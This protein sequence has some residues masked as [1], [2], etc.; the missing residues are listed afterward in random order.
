MARN[1]ILHARLLR[2]SCIKWML[3][4]MS[5]L[6]I[7]RSKG[8]LH[9]TL[10]PDPSL[11]RPASW[12]NATLS[13][14]V[15]LMKYEKVFSTLSEFS[16]TKAV[17]DENITVIDTNFSDIPVR[18]YFLKKNSEKQRPA[19]IFI[20]GGIFV[21]GSVKCCQSISLHDS[22]SEDYKVSISFF[23]E[24]PANDALNRLT[25]KKLG[26]V[27]VGIDYRL[28]PKN[29]FPASLED[30]IFAVKFFLQDKVLAKYRVDPARICIAGDSSGASLVALVTQTLQNDP[31]FKG[32]IKAQALIY[33]GLQMI[34]SYLPSHQDYEHGPILFRNMAFKL[35]SLY[36]SEDTA[37]AQAILRNEHMP[38][39]SRHLFKF[40][41]WSYFLPEKYKKN[42]VYTEPILGKLNP[43]YP[44]LVDSRLSPLLASDSQLQS[45]PL[46]YILTCEHDLVRDDG[47]IYLSRLRNVGV[48]VTHDHIED[49]IHAALSYTT[50]TVVLQLGFRIRDRYINWLV[51]NL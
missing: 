42:H 48:Q 29:I 24:V 37:L 14:N 43:S 8:R 10:I 35:V 26:A 11:L 30:C 9:W 27:V 34:D 39:G 2:G 12:D 49:G 45:V 22:Q 44:A 13:E 18:L 31:E 50:G 36:V 47:L 19:V 41:N 46:T 4:W 23:S 25:A 33:P 40:V 7:P 16:F 32:R 15:G 5:L 51:E 1:M 28:A 6:M 3:V 20:H 17:S 38:E 21:F